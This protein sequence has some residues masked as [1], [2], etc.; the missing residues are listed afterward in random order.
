[1]HILCEHPWEVTPDLYSYRD[2]EEMEKE[3]QATNEKAVERRD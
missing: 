2:P 1:M 3:E